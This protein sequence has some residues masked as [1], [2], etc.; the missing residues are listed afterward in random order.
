M[1]TIDVDVSG[2][3]NDG[4]SEGATFSTSDDTWEIGASSGNDKDGFIRFTGISGLSGATIT[5]AEVNW[6]TRSSELGTMVCDI[7][8]RGGE[9]SPAAP[10]TEAE[11]NTDIAAI[12]SAVTSFS[13]YTHVADGELMGGDATPAPVDITGSID[14]IKG[15][16]PSEILV[17]G[18]NNGSDTSGLDYGRFRS[19][20]RGGVTPANLFIDYEEAAAEDDQP[21]Y[22][23]DWGIARH[24]RVLS[25]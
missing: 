17:L 15:L 18:I 12:T 7:G 6:P 24:V 9:A 4:H 23:Q 1:P 10:T 5:V 20:D 11:F 25:Y 21:P 13:S 22:V 16:D 8:V 19:I 3:A 2:S 14:E